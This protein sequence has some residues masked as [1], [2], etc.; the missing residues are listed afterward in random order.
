MERAK[1]PV[2]SLSLTLRNTKTLCFKNVKPSKWVKTTSPYSNLQKLSIRLCSRVKP[3]LT[4]L[5]G[6]FTVIPRHPLVGRGGDQLLELRG[7]TDDGLLHGFSLTRKSCTETFRRISSWISMQWIKVLL[8]CIQIDLAMS[9]KYFCL[10][11]LILKVVH[12]TFCHHKNHLPE[13]STPNV[14]QGGSSGRSTRS[15]QIWNAVLAN[16]K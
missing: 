4:L 7:L 3:P 2:S 5:P 10:W 11:T 14:W 1:V 13:V 6:D 15:T 9:I 16:T 12:I 8:S